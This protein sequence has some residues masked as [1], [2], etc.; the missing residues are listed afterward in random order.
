MILD[1]TVLLSDDQA[2]TATANSTNTIDLGADRDIGKGV[3]VPLLVQ[4]TEDFDNLTSLTI[5]VQTDDNDSFSSA[6]TLATTGAIPL[7]SLVAGYQAP[8]DFVPRGTERYVRL[9][10]TVTGVAP[11]AGKVTAGIVLDHQQGH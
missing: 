2:I 5:A 3:P 6:T 10:Y 7:A 9:A 8:L 4:V 1:E 11:T